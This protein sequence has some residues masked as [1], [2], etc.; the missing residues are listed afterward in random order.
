MSAEDLTLHGLGKLVLPAIQQVATVI[1]Q[2][3]CAMATLSAI[4][5]K[6]KLG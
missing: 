6:D 1:V 3:T 5:R 4:K 2:Q